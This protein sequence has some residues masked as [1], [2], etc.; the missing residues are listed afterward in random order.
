M[1]SMRIY[2]VG[3]KAI[4]IEEISHWWVAPMAIG[5]PSLCI[6]MRNGK[7]ISLEVTDTPDGSDGYAIEAALIE[8]ISRF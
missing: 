4:V 5:G 2:R 8:F 1:K 6:S 3:S 7:Q